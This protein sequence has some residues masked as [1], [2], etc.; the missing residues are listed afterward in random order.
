MAYKWPWLTSII[1]YLTCDFNRINFQ[2]KC[3][4]IGFVWGKF[5]NAC[6]FVNA[7]ALQRS[8]P[9]SEDAKIKRPPTLNRTRCWIYNR[10]TSGK[11]S[12][13]VRGTILKL[14]NCGINRGRI[15]S[16]L[17]DLSCLPTPSY[18]FSSCARITSMTILQQTL[19]WT[20][21]KL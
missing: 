2:N 9:H 17:V 20:H 3:S 5:V 1:F 18:T 16:L 21:R 19:N 15:S 12:K 11:S 8:H 10:F 13:P 6:K 14:I 7:K 4:C